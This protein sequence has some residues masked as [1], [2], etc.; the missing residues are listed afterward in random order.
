[1]RSKIKKLTRLQMISS[2]YLEEK[3]ITRRTI[4]LEKITMWDKLRNTTKLCLVGGTSMTAAAAGKYLLYDRNLSAKN[5][6][7]EGEN[8]QLEEVADN[9]AEE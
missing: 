9:T 7:S 5:A 6:L 8:Y 2:L 3:M 1:M 4:T